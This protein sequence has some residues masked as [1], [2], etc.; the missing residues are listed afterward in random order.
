MTSWKIKWQ[1]RRCATQPAKTEESVTKTKIA[2]LDLTG[3]TGCQVNLL[4][5]G[6]AFL[7]FAQYF[8]IASWRMLQAGGATDYDVV[9][10]EGYACNEEQ[11]ELLKQARETCELVVAIGVCSISGHVFS[12][13]TAEN[14]EKLKAIV[15]SPEHRTVTKFVKPVSNV[16]KVDHVIPG[17][18]ANVEAARKL[19][20]ELKQRHIT[21]KVKEVRYPDYV[22]RIE[23]HGSLNVDFK[24][25]TAHFCPEEG[26]RFVE[27]LVVGKPY[28]AAP[29][30]HSRICGICPV[31]HCLCSIK[32]IEKALGI[33]P[34]SLSKRLRRIFQCGQ[35]VQSH[36]LHLYFM[37]LPYLTGLKSSV[38]MSSRYPLEFHLYLDIKCLTEEI[39]DLIGGAPL[40]PVSLTAGGFS[41]LT[42]A[43][44]L[45]GLK[46]NILKVLDKSHD[47]VALF[48][49][50]DWPEAVTNAHM[51]CIQPEFTNT[52]PMFGGRICFNGPIPFSVDDYRD[53]IQEIIVCDHPSKVGYLAPEKPV[54]TGALARLS[55][56]WHRLNPL[57]KKAFEESKP[58]FCNPFHNNLAQAVEILHYLEEAALLLDTLKGDDLRKTVV[59]RKKIRRTALDD[60][61]PWP[62]RG[63]SAIEAPRGLLFHEV[64]VDKKGNVVYYNIIP[65]TVLNLS[66]LD[67]EA[68]LLLRTYQSEPNDKKT[69]LLEELIRAMDPCVTCA[70][71]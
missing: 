32:A 29:R 60:E 14:Y 44:R 12:Q 35:I 62:R 70:V 24:D 31:A 41:R 17:C 54:K 22:A 50:F 55:Y 23:G 25:G 45:Q 21:S 3:C 53:F 6:S 39:F 8:E 4:R 30:I 46:G 9:F 10:V 69:E 68:I 71:H 33:R 43:D 27:A 52:Y 64:Q 13:L 11:V 63:V 26:E 19:L 16:V 58:M 65:P 48:A 40:H 20:H 7:D 1:R 67:H 15:Y 34:S 38:E 18:P 59:D 36:L 37:V 66:S 2:I 42:D 47:L 5:L 51:L 56:Y 61:S 57:A 28:L 49:G